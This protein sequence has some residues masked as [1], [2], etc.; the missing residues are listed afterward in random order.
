MNFVLDAPKRD[1]TGFRPE[2]RVL[3]LAMSSIAYPP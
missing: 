1:E 2:L 3:A